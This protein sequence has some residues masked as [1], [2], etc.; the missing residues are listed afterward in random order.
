MNLILSF[1]VGG[2]D[3]EWHVDYS[4][5]T[6]DTASE[7]GCGAELSVE[8]AMLLTHVAAVGGLR[9]VDIL[10]LIAEV[11]GDGVPADIHQS[12]LLLADEALEAARDEYDEGRAQ[13]IADAQTADAESGRYD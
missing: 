2:Q 1:E 13:A 8:K 10:D 4:P 3:I 9:R 6:Q 11:S 5:E 12:L 7:P